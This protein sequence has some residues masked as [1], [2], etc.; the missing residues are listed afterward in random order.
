MMSWRTKFDGHHDDLKEKKKVIS[1]Q[2]GV[3]GADPKKIDTKSFII[4]FEI[5]QQMSD[6]SFIKYFKI[7]L[8]RLG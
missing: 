4:N 3:N 7:I 5:F 2:Y 6:S 8:L 1:R